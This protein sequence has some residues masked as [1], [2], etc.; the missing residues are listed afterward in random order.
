MTNLNRRSLLKTAA[1]TGLALATP[2][3]IRTAS[4]RTT[5]I[6]VASLLGDDKPETK[7]W[8]KIAELVDARLPGQFKFNIVKNGALGGEKEV[9]EGTRLGSVH[10]S[11]ST[12]SSLSGWVP[13]LQ[14][15]D[16]P[17]LF[18]DAA[19]VRRTVDGDVGTDLKQKLAAQNFVVGDFINY[20]ARHLLAKEAV[21]RP[22]QLKGKKIRVIQSPLHT[23]LWSAFGTTPVGI[24][25]TET[26]NALST[27]VA[28]AMDL[29]KSAYAGFKLYEV[30]PYMTETGHIWA[31]GVIFY[32]SGFWKQLNDEQKTV[33]QDA[34]RQGAAYFNQLIVEDEARS[35]EQSLKNGGK[36]LKPEA[37]DEWQKGAQGVWQDFAGI[38]GGIERIKTIQT[39]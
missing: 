20:G 10:A 16:L 39:A 35:V 1:T 32:A 38:V 31:S 23:K 14:I 11:L 9:A 2:A 4:A 29:T 34:S 17:F 37:F 3:F 6:T 12:V 30:V 24:P 15:L 33:F 5:T 7:V 28:D 8:V 21:T 26:Y 13:E 25:I 19:H 18:R 36:L 22:E 27:G